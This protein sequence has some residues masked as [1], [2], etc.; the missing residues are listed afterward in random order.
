MRVLPG[1]V[2]QSLPK[3]PSELRTLKLDSLVFPTSVFASLEYKAK[4][5]D[6]GI[7]FFKVL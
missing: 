7:H 1:F 4:T 6:V 2:P 5:L 3:V